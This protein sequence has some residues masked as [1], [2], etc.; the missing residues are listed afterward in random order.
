M[1]QLRAALTMPPQSG[2][3]GRMPSPRNPSVPIVNVT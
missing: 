2:V 3:G 1:I